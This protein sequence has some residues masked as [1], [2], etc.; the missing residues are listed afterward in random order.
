VK[1]FNI[2]FPV[3]VGAYDAHLIGKRF[4][5]ANIPVMLTRVHSL[6]E[7]DEDAVDLPFKLPFLLNQ[8]GIKFC[9]QNSGDMETMNARNI[10]FLAGTAMAYGLTEEEALRAISLSTCEILG[11]DKKFGSIEVGKS[12]TL[13]VSVGPALDMRTNKVSLILVNGK[14]E[15]VTNFQT[16]LYNK[17]KKKYEEKQK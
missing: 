11:I 6:P 8:Q 5:D 3:I 15:S 9:L 13:F 1:E 16:D 4:K 12:A 10:P 7:L 2:K 17:Y 14:F